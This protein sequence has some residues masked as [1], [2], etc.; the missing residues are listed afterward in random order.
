MIY[1]LGQ[2]EHCECGCERSFELSGAAYLVP[3]SSA[4][5]DRRISGLSASISNKFL[6]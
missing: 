5:I 2:Y 3:E 1:D 6:L 4:F